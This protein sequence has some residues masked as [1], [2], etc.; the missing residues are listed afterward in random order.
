MP[1]FEIIAKMPITGLPN[2]LRVEK[3]EAFTVRVPPNC[4]T[5][6]ADVTAK[7]MCVEQL[8]NSSGLDFSKNINYLSGGYFDYRKIF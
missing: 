4:T 3:G 6:F 1:T 5:P 7:Q 8:K 2:N